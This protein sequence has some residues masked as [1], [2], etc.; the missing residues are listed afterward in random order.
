[1]IIAITGPM[2]SGKTEVAK[3]LESKGFEYFAFS[4]ILR[5]EAKKRGIEPTRDNLQKL[6]NRIKKEANNQGVLSDIIC[7]KV[8]KNAAADGVRNLD[9]IISFRKRKDFKLIGVTASPR[10]RYSRIK[11]RARPG[12]PETYQKFKKLD[13][14]ENRGYTKAQDIN[15]CVNEADF[16]IVN[17]GTLEELRKKVDEILA[18]IN[19]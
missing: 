12:D 13:N 4:D 7:N 17:N 9:E 6:G 2:A 11:K 3:Y 18:K 5:E 1:M 15:N 10:A 19:A 14:M 8:K 16:K